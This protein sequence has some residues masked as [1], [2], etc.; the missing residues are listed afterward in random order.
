MLLQPNGASFEKD[1]MLGVAYVWKT[2]LFP[3]RVMFER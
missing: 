2:R 3:P 1:G